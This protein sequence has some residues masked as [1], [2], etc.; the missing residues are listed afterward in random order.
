[1]KIRILTL[2]AAMML[3]AS[4]SAGAQMHPQSRPG[5]APSGHGAF[6]E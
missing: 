5:R 3:V 6:A 4:F 1:M 2:M